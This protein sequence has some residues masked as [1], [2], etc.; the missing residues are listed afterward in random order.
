VGLRFWER[1]YFFP[2]CFQHLRGDNRCLHLKI[3]DC[4]AFWAAAMVLWCLACPHAGNTQA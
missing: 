4:R 1:A 2:N 3:D